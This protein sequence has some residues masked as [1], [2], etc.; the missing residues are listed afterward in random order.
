MKQIPW[1]RALK[2]SSAAEA[3]PFLLQDLDERGDPVLLYALHGFTMALH[4]REALPEKER[5][6]LSSGSLICVQ[7]AR[8]FH[9]AEVGK[10]AA[11]EHLCPSC[12]AQQAEQILPFLTKCIGA[13]WNCSPQSSA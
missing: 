2:Y 8:C 13:G 3:I 6:H 11:A 5:W 12:R 7:V 4:S 9:Q 10:E 1:S